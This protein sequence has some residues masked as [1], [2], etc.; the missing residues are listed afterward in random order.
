M[1]EG[2]YN[3]VVSGRRKGGEGE[4]GRAWR[5]PKVLFGAF[6]KLAGFLP[7]SYNM[8]RIISFFSD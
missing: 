1:K 5:Y 2:I 8:R 6:H 7:I 3:V 4:E